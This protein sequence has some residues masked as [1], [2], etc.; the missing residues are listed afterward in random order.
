[1]CACLLIHVIAFVYYV[2]SGKLFTFGD[3]AWGQLGLG[4]NNPVNKPT[5]VKGLCHLHQDFPNFQSALVD[6]FE[7]VTH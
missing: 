1:M 2:D 3:N 7:L 6:F 4:H 5:R